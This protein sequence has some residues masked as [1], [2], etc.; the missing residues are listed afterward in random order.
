MLD[1]RVHDQT[2][3]LNKKYKR[4]TMDYEELHQ[5]VIEMRSQ[6]SGTCIPPN[7]PH[8]LDDD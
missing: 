5:V 8:S 2:T 4:R 1:Q 7:W 3:H 6:M